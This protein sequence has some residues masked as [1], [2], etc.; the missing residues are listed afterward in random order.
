[1]T[2]SEDTFPLSGLINND[3]KR[4]TRY[5]RPKTFSNYRSIDGE[6]RPRDELV[7]DV[8]PTPSSRGHFHDIRDF[9]GRQLSE[10]RNVRFHGANVKF[11][12]IPLI[13][14]VVITTSMRGNVSRLKSNFSYLKL[15]YLMPL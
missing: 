7:Y 15:D 4:I 13:F 3:E 1:M 8:L 12:D 11:Y 9:N 14:L 6:A 5:G 2:D 10:G